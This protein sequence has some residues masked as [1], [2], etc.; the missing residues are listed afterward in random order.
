MDSLH[1]R[2]V[3]GDGTREQPF[4]IHTSN[5]ML[6]AK[7][8]DEIIDRLFGAGA[9]KFS[10]VYY[11]SRRGKPGNVDLRERFSLADGIRRSVWFDL[12]LVSALVNDP[13]L[14]KAKREL[15][16]SPEMRKVLFEAG[17]APNRSGCLGVIFL[18]ITTVTITLGGLLCRSLRIF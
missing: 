8:Q 16:E 15:M 13:A 18:A 17:L 6:S 4:V 10:V 1:D 9:S 11:E 5:E 3:E 7:I 14:N 2:I 12:Y